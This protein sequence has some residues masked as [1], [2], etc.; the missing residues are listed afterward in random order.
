MFL[1]R[2]MIEKHWKLS[3][4]ANVHIRKSTCDTKRTTFAMTVIA[5]GKALKPVNI[6]KGV[7]GG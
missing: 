7:R 6:L 2:T 3:G 1:S 5:S 4:V